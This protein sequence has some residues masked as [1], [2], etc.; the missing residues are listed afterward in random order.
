MNNLICLYLKIND[1][2][3]IY[4]YQSPIALIAAKRKFDE[5]CSTHE[6]NIKHKQRQQASRWGQ[7]AA[8]TVTPGFSHTHKGIGEQTGQEE[9]AFSRHGFSF[10]QTHWPFSHFDVVVIVCV[11]LFLTQQQLTQQR[12]LAPRPC[13][14]PLYPCIQRTKQARKLST[15]ANSKKCTSTI[16]SCVCV[17]TFFVCCSVRA[18]RLQCRVPTDHTLTPHTHSLKRCSSVFAGPQSPSPRWAW[19][20]WSR[21]EIWELKACCWCFALLTHSF[22]HHQLNKSLSFVLF[23]INFAS[24]QHPF[25]HICSFY[26]RSGRR[27]SSSAA[28]CPCSQTPWSPTLR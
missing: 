22:I 20:S 21:W 19:R 6:D 2:Y 11:W 23:S 4:L 1:C 18:Q 3:Y 14:R 28:P 8:C 10:F 15:H 26:H 7:W 25:W 12:F 16:V 27:R 5:S 17:W 13:L 24:T 9:T